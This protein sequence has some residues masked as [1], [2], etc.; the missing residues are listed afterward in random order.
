M[1]EGLREDVECLEKIEDSE[2]R[3]EK[4]LEIRRALNDIGRFIEV[5]AEQGLTPRGKE[6]TGLR[7]PS[8]PSAQTFIPRYWFNWGIPSDSFLA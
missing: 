3:K 7:E 2:Q 1:L 5:Y 6:M 4:E 8:D